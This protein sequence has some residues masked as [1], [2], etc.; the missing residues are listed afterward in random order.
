MVHIS[1]EQ[2]ASF[3][4]DGFLILPAISEGISNNIVNWTHEIKNLP[5]HSNAWMHYEEIDAKGQRTLCRTENFANYHDGFNK[6]F[7]GDEILGILEQLSGEKMVLFKEKINYKAPWAGGFRP[8]TDSPAY[9]HVA[10]VKHLSIL[11]AAE[12]AT[13][14]NGCLE[15][16]AGSHKESVPI[17]NDNC[18]ETS[19]CDKQTW[20]PVPLKTGEFLIFGSYLAHRS[21]PNNSPNG[22]AA[23]YATYNAVSDGG[24]KHDAYYADR[25]KNWPPTADRVPGEKYAK[26]AK[27]YGY[28]FLTHAFYFSSLRLIIF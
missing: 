9:Q 2:K 14:D 28:S 16:V 17:G 4:R 8:H 10:N 12:P 25:R 27:V 6:L 5:H 24:D 18:I 15:V 13:L 26:G 23:I 3:E 1:A 22:R 19:W 21:G 11:M 7:R 20:T